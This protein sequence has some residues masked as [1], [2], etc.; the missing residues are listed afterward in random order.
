MLRKIS[1]KGLIGQ[2]FEVKLTKIPPVTF[3]YGVNGS[4]KSLFLKMTYYLLSNQ[5]FNAV[6][7]PFYN[8]K[9]MFDE[10]KFVFRNTGIHIQTE[11]KTGRLLHR[12]VHFPVRVNYYEPDMIYDMEFEFPKSK[13]NK[14]NRVFKSLINSMF[15]FKTLFATKGKK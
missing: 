3:I 6:D 1:V 7:I 9:I 4:G 15:K 11:D 2:R 12:P 14:R 13:D 10:E 5:D 8:A